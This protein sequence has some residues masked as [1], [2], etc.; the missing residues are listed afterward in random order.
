MTTSEQ[1]YH[2]LRIQ[3]HSLDSEVELLRARKELDMGLEEPQ[4][5]VAA[6]ESERRGKRIEREFEMV[7]QRW[8]A[9]CEVV[10]RGIELDQRTAHAKISKELALRLV[11]QVQDKNR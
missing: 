1:T 9:K 7:V 4:V 11:T 5:K 3:H 2:D 6:A 10:R 8:Q